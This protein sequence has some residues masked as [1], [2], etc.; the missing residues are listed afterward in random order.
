MIRNWDFHNLRMDYSSMYGDIHPSDIDMFFIGENNVLIIG[1]I[2]NECY[3]REKWQKQKKIF[4]RLIDNYKK[5]A[6]CLFITH[7]KYWQDG[8]RKVNVPECYVKEYYYKNHKNWI[9][10]RKPI[11]VKEV[12]EKYK[13]KQESEKKL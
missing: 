2:K 1:E 3:D 6:M 8:D 5:E 13:I 12:L 4:E 9:T 11:K 10:P 7:N